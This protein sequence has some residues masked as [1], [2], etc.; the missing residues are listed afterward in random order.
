[1]CVTDLYV[2]QAIA[3]ERLRRLRRPAS[4]SPAPPSA[5][6]PVVAMA[7]APSGPATG[8]A[9][10]A[11]SSAS[12]GN[13]TAPAGGATSATTTPGGA[14]TNPPAGQ[15]PSVDPEQVITAA[16]DAVLASGDPALACERYA[17]A[18]Y[19]GTTFGSRGGC[20]HSTVPA[21]AADSVEVSAIRISGSTAKA[22]A[23]PSGGPSDGEKISVALV[24]EDRVWKVDSLHSNV[25][26]GP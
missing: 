20:V 23:V 13:T 14:A 3:R 17:T 22:T 2:A 6:S 12:T 24:N 16:I 9:V 7:A 18:D 21:S 25:P 4:S 1:M 19:V 11:G 8:T 15:E 26:V 10:A 5:S